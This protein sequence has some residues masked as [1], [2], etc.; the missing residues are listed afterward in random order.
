M[1]GAD[2]KIYGPGAGTSVAFSG[3]SAAAQDIGSIMTDYPPH[4]LASH[5]RAWE[6]NHRSW[7]N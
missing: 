4:F 7:M 6:I 2:I 5:F 3:T 1:V